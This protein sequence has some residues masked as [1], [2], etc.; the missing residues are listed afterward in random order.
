MELKKSPEENLDNRKWV[1]AM[2]AVIFVGAL[3]LSLTEYRNMKLI[4]KKKDEKKINRV[5]EEEIMDLPENQPPP[6]SSSPGNFSNKRLATIASIIESPRNSRRSL[7]SRFSLSLENDLC[8][9]ATLNRSVF[10]GRY[11]NLPIT[12]L[13]IL[14]SSLDFFFGIKFTRNFKL[15][16]VFGKNH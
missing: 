8:V 1:F 6:P 7:D 2:V 15:L 11:P 16:F 10:R 9:R 13:I 14:I 4:E 12:N 3:S 5:D